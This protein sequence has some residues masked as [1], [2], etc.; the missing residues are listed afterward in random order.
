MQILKEI[1]EYFKVS[2]VAILKRLRKMKY[3]Y[4]KILEYKERDDKKRAEYW[5]K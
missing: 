5:E 4:K 2:D 1:W 3:S